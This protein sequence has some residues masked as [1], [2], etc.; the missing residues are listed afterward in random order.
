MSDATQAEGVELLPGFFNDVTDGAYSSKIY[1]NYHS[2][3]SR[4][5]Y[6]LAPSL[7][8][9]SAL[10]RHLST[11]F[12]R[13]HRNINDATELQQRPRRSFVSRGPRI[14]EVA[15]V[16]DREVIFTAPPPPQKTQQQTQSHA[17]GSSTTPPAPCTNPTT[18]LPRYAHS[19]PVRLL[20]HLVLFFCCASPQHANADAQS[21]QQQ[22]GQSQGQVQTQVS[23][24]L[25]QPT[26]ASTSTTPPAPA[27]ST[28]TSSAVIM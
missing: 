10:F 9:A 1:G 18:S 6:P 11:P 12:R 17:Q 16:K 22:Q 25:T 8:S 28:A 4:S 5:P 7:W 2:S 20:A 21:T 26:A 15:A 24:S 14:A 23:S 19:P 13:Y 3:S 27:T